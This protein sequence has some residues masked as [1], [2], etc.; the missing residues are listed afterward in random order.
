MVLKIVPEQRVSELGRLKKRAG[1]DG[2]PD[3]IIG[4]DWLKERAEVK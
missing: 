3:D 4:M 2:D 1:F